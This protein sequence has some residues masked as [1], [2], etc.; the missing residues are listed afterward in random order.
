VIRVARGVYDAMIAHALE[1]RPFECCGLLAGTDSEIVR[2]DRATNAADYFGIR[3]AID[4]REYMRLDR[5]IDDADLNV[6]GVYHSHPYTRAYPSA[7]D[8]GHAF[9][10]MVYV[11]VSLRDFLAPEVKAFTVVGGQVF[12]QPIEVVEAVGQDERD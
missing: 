2:C 11:I 9:E 3:Y 7:T 4:P 6:I 12:E 1:E 10:G 5:E 8:T